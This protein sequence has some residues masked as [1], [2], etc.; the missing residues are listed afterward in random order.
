MNS[1]LPFDFSRYLSPQSQRQLSEPDQW[2]WISTFGLLTQRSVRHP[3]HE[4]WAKIKGNT[5]SPGHREVMLTLRGQAIYSIGGKCYLRRPGTVVL[6]DRHENRDLKG[7]P[8]KT[9]F[10]CLWVHLYNREYLTYYINSCDAAGRYVHELPLQTKSGDHSQLILD[11]WDQ[12]QANPEDP[13]ARALLKSLIVST[14]LSLLGTAPTTV[15]GNPHEQVVASLKTYITSHLGE[16]LSLANLAKLAGYSP[17]FLH[18][19]FQHQV[20][21]TPVQYVN[22]LRLARSVELLELG[23]T[24][25]SVADSVGFSSLSYFSAFFK[26]RLGQPPGKWRRLEIKTLVK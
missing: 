26:K 13:L 23:H 18:R 4:K 3:A 24:V 12:A 6:L 21:K 17:F 1:K 8:N 2:T 11:V 14:L 19:F 9:A 25:E 5:Y 16:D 15:S 10:S 22:E 7:S 20:G